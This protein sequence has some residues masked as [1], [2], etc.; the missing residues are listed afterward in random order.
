MRVLIAGAA[1]NLGSHLARYLKPT[2][3]HLNLMVHHKALPSDLQESRNVSVFKADL[4]DP[5]TLVEACKYSECIVHFAGVLFAPHPEIFLP[6]TNLQYVKNLVD[7][8]LENNV[9]KFILISFPHVEGESTL[10]KPARGNLGGIPT[11]V[12]AKTRLAA[13][14]YLFNQSRERKMTAI[15]LRPG[16]IYAKRV[17][18]IDVARSLLSRRLLAVWNEPTYIHLLSLPD[19][20]KC[21]RLTI[22]NDALKGVYNLGDEQPTTLQAFLDAAAQQWGLSKPWRLPK[23]LFPFAGWCCEQFAMVFRTRSLLTQDFIKIGMVSY[24]C[25]TSRMKKEIMPTLEFPTLKDGLTLL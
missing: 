3:H 21:V 16:M 23:W 9:K 2:D 1:G 10:E 18:M 24:V 14:E 25:D 20:L 22:E 15:A 13:E 12:H 8:A 19:F 5:K 11:S 4:E 6:R 17:L 7:V